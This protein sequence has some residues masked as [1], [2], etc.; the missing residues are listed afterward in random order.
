MVCRLRR[1]V[2]SLPYFQPIRI[3][4][5]RDDIVLKR[6]FP[7]GRPFR[8]LTIK[9]GGGG[10]SVYERDGNPRRLA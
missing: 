3:W 1:Q 5:V 2:P 8:S 7:R 9:P 10:N 4:G 6:A